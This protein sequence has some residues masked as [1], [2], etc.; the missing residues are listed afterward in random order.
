MFSMV[1][2]PSF[3]AVRVGFRAYAGDVSTHA[4]STFNKYE[5]N[6]RPNSLVPLPPLIETNTLKVV[7]T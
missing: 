1:S 4:G 2:Y 5:N 3:Q 7:T 6:V